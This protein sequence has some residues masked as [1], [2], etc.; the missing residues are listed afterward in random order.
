MNIFRRAVR[1]VIPDSQRRQINRALNR[2]VLR[3]WFGRE[4]REFVYRGSAVEC[5]CCGGQFSEFLPFGHNQRPNVVCPRCGVHERHRL[6][7]LYL[8]RETDL[9]SAP[10]TLLHFAPERIFKQQLVK[11]RNLRY[12]TTDLEAPEADTFMD[13]TGLALPDDT[14]DVL[15]CTH[16]LEHIPDDRAAMRELFRVMQPGGWAII[17]VPLD[18]TR[19]TSLEDPNIVTAQD[20]QRY[21]WQHDHVRLYGKDY[22]ER[23]RQVGFEVEFLPYGERFTEAERQRYGLWTMPIC[24]CRKPAQPQRHPSVSTVE[25]A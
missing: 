2:Y 4:V 25:S 3:G 7:W 14:F 20:R 18:L 17:E 22:F 13:I 15:F 8:N 5:P 21:Y 6:Y 9:F 11:Q 19:E 23:L 1:A 12:L 16:V 10:H 24:I